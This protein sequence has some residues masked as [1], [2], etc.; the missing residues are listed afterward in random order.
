MNIIEAL[1]EMCTLESL[2]EM[3]IDIAVVTILIKLIMYYHF[4]IKMRKI[5][6]KEFSD[7]LDKAIKQIEDLMEELKKTM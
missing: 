4:K 5:A 2:T 6:Q 3:L 7:S 1:T